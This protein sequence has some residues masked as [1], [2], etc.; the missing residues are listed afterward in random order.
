MSSPSC[1]KPSYMQMGKTSGNSSRARR[2]KAT[3]TIQSLELCRLPQKP[4]VPDISGCVMR[5]SR[6]GIGRHDNKKVH[7]H[8]EVKRLTGSGQKVD[9][10]AADRYAMRTA[11]ESEEERQQKGVR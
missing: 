4:A 10:G 2:F 5:G 8:S 7:G 11:T 1:D 9:H 6:M 3:G